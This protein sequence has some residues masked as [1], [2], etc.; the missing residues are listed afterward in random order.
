MADQ[1]EL[2]PVPFHEDTI[3]AVDH[4]GEPYTAMRPIIQN[5]GLDWKNQYNKLLANRERWSVVKITTVAD[6]GKNRE[7]V[8]IPVRK[9]AG[10]LATINHNKV[11]NELRA[12][13]LAYQHECDDVLWEYWSGGAA[14]A[15]GRESFESAQNDWAAD[16]D[17]IDR[18][19]VSANQRIRL[20][21]LSIKF[22]S[23]SPAER[24]R[25]LAYYGDFCKQAARDGGNNGK[26]NPSRNP[27]VPD[28]V[29]RFVAERCTVGSE[30]I[31]TKTNLYGCYR[32]FCRQRQTPPLP[33]VAFFKSLYAITHAR[34][35]RYRHS[36][37]ENRRWAVAGIGLN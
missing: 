29:R 24:Q 20:L 10:F 27:R 37:D 6:D 19:D 16:L 30:R 36:S 21:S 9:L 31:V 35:V 12:K 14:P 22:A 32:E 13:V 23:L 18:G 33:K 26:H 5:M 1:K 4:N 8:C 17:A 2:T 28:H 25:A 3:Y 7:V 11:R 34:P 15:A